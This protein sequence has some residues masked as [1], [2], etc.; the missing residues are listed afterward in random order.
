MPSDNSKPTHLRL[1]SDEKSWR[2]MDHTIEDCVKQVCGQY[3]EA[4]VRD[5]ML[6][7]DLASNPEIDRIDRDGA[8]LT[9][10]RTAFLHH[11]RF[12]TALE[13]FLNEINPVRGQKKRR[14][15]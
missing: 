10:Q 5:F 15:A 14:S 1:A 13:N 8:V 2:E 12:E 6:L 7:I 11:P 3:D 9:M 4:T